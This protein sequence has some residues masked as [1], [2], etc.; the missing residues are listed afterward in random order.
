M[1]ALQKAE[2]VTPIL[3][4]DIHPPYLIFLGEQV[5]LKKLM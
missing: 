1:M 4:F 3:R 2:L 5:G